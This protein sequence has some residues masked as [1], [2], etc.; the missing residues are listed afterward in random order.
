MQF[1]FIIVMTIFSASCRFVSYLIYQL[2]RTGWSTDLPA[3]LVI[4]L[5][6]KDASAEWKTLDTVTRPTVVFVYL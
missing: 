3:A 1:I 5:S 6:S 4:G 2:R